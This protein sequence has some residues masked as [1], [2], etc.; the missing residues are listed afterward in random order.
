MRLHRELAPDRLDAF[1]HVVQPD[2]AAA[3]FAY[4]RGVE[5]DSVVV[6]R[7]AQRAAAEGQAQA[8]VGAG[9]VLLR[10][11]QRFLRDAEEHGLHVVGQIGCHALDF[12]RE[13]HARLRA[14]LF[15][16]LPQRGRQAECVEHHRPQSVRHAAHFQQRVL[17]ARQ[18]TRQQ[19]AG[20][21]V[22][23]RAA[24]QRRFDQQLHRHQRLPR[25]VV[26]F[27]RKMHPF[28]LLRI[29]HLARQARELGIAL[30]VFAE[31]EHQRAGEDQRHAQ[32]AGAADPQHGAALTGRQVV[33]QLHHHRV[34][35]VQINAGAH[36]PAPAFKLRHVAQLGRDLLR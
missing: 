24:V 16:Q 6:D 30:A 31:A 8:D 32:A 19:R 23:R 14:R 10:V 26:Q 2:A 28:F 29:D 13:L 7:Q 20:R 4:R 17:Q 33:V 15:T 9:R 22:R 11:G 36:H 25:A 27:T 5:A 18:R 12:H 35:F 3:A 21:F 34:H 1:A